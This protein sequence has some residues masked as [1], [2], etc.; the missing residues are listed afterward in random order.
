MEFLEAVND[1]LH[2][3]MINEG[4]AKNTVDAYRR[5]LTNYRLFMLEKNIN[6]NEIVYKD[7]IAWVNQIQQSR[8]PTSVNR[9]VSSIT[10]FH[11]FLFEYYKIIDPTVKLSVSRARNP[12]PKTLTR[13]EINRL[14]ES[15]PSTPLGE[16][17]KTLCEVLFATG[18]RVSEL[19]Q[20]Q[21]QQVYVEEGILRIVGKGDKERI[22]PIGK[23]ALNAYKNYIEHIRPGWLKKGS[24]AVFIGPKGKQLSRQYVWSMLKYKSK[25]LD[26]QPSISPHT[27]RHSF[28]SALLQGGADLRIIQ[29]LLGHSDI[30]T[31]QIYT[32]IESDR[33]HR[34][35][36]EFHP[37]RLLDKENEDE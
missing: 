30:S 16:Y 27:L 10:G 32:H 33:L 7:L 31:T 22:I 23:S 2:H 15:F 21:F 3:C 34:N 17:Q 8:K 5:D 9:M 18:L 13:A 35:Y 25:E 19:C 26:L 4:K 29:E 6:L 28:A 14:L 11:R 12:L 37:G 36:D 20:L 1:F 24:S